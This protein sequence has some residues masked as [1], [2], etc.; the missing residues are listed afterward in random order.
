MPPRNSGFSFAAIFPALEPGDLLCVQSLDRIEVD[1]A[2]IHIASDH[3]ENVLAAVLASRERV[4]SSTTART[5]E[6][7]TAALDSAQAT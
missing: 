5:L 6:G 4:L 2:A 7:A 3:G 1:P